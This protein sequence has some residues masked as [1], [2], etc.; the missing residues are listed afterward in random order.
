MTLHI[1]DTAVGPGENSPGAGLGTLSTE[2]GNLPLHGLDITTHVT[3]LVAKTVITQ[4]FRN[5][6]PDTIEAEYI[7]PLPHRAAVTAMTMRVADREVS[8]RLQER[9]EARAAYSEALKEGKRAAIAEAER[10]DVFTMRVGNI[11]SR[12]SA[13]VTL[14]LVGPLAVED[15]EATVRVPL[16]VAPRYIP[17]R[18]LDG[19]C[20]GGGQIPDTEEVPDASRIT[21]PVLLPG[22]PNPVELSITVTIN[23]AGLRLHHVT[24]SL[25][26]VEVDTDGDR[27]TVRIHP[28]ERV[29][30]DFILRLDYGDDRISSSLAST[31]THAD[32]EGTFQLTV[33]PPRGETG[34]RPRD[35]VVLLDR[36]GSM[37]GWKMAAARRAAARI[38]DTLSDDD[39]FAV[40][41]FDNAMTQPEG[42]D[43]LAWATDRNR[44]T[45]VEHLSRAEA[46]GGTELLRPLS[47]A[48]DLLAGDTDRDRIIV[49]VTDGQVGNEDRIIAELH[50]RVAGIRVHVVG[51]D[52]AVNTA[53]LHRLALLGRGRC[54]L[55]ESHDRLDTAIGHIHRRI[56]APVVTDVEVA[57]TSGTIVDE[58]LAPGRIGDLFTGVPLVVYGR[59]RGE[60]PILRVSGTDASGRPWSAEPTVDQTVDNEAIDAMWAR[61]RL[62]DLEDAYAATQRE[63]ELKALEKTMVSTSLASDVLSRFTA[64]VAVDVDIVDGRDKPRTIVQPVEYPQGW[65][66]PEPPTKQ[67]MRLAAA[68]MALTS[69]PSGFAPTVSRPG[70]AGRMGRALGR[71]AV[72]RPRRNTTMPRAVVCEAL[73]SE[74][75]L[76]KD[77]EEATDQNL[78]TSLS[79]MGTRLRPLLSA[80]AAEDERDLGTLMG[81]LRDLVKRLGECENPNPDGADTVQAVRRD[82][83]LLLKESARVLSADQPGKADDD[84]LNGRSGQRADRPFWKR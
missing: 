48:C 33:V 83:L 9:G 37:K 75:A 8:A 26:A 64:F 43:S 29:N 34:P 74:L 13:T 63:T 17:G 79:D 2:H 49:L 6:H 65:H 5:P 56:V 68:P 38:V 61:S 66:M 19:P 73:H 3:G 16:V 82:A 1:A 32:G 77:L 40:R 67:P 30:R 69:P 35:V 36:S 18:P 78:R 55:V 53:F 47:T 25:H 62:L 46:R 44:Y 21:P 22:F 31:G 76:L 57:A 45:A 20:V 70:S 27:R 28:G 39:R 59:Y 52:R 4:R 72:Q 54:E 81:R 11:P 42:L 41:C 14:T 51:I 7:F 60:P 50:E 58:T 12:E 23:P 10:G 84:A 80:L 71:P 24:S 15:G